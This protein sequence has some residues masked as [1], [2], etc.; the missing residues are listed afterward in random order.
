M[1]VD[2]SVIV[3]IAKAEPDALKFVEAM[4]DAEV[5]IS[6]GSV[7]ECAHVL[8]PEFADQLDD[9]IRATELEIVPF[10]TEQLASA[11]KAMATYGRGSGSS[12]GLNFGDCFSY[13]LAKVRNEP[14]LFKGHDFTHTDVEAARPTREASEASAPL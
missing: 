12:A 1:I 10:D 4:R 3:A 11:R 6:A 9:L 14:L 5:K 8:R 7:L 2:S 13:A